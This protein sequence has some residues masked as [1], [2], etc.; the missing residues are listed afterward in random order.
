MASGS[1]ESAQLS[2]LLSESHVKSGV[3]LLPHFDQ[4]RKWAKKKEENCHCGSLK[5]QFE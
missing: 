2:S 5:A 3:V 4:Q 1:L